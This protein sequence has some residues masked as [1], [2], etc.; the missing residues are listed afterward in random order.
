M[1]KSKMWKK[2]LVTLAL[3]LTSVLAIGCSSNVE[4]AAAVAEP[5][6]FPTRTVATEPLPGATIAEGSDS[7]Y[8]ANVGE[9]AASE[10]EDTVSA[11]A[12]GEIAAGE[13]SDSEAAG[14]IY[15]LEEE[16]LARDVYLTLQE[17]WGMNIL[18]NI[19]R[20]EE[21]H[22][23]AVKTLI[24]RYNLID[25]VAGNAIGEFTDRDL[26]SLYDELVEKGSQSLQAALEV[27]AA[28]EE[29][30]IIDLEQYMAQTDEQDIQRVYENLLQGSK[31]HL[32]SFVSVYE[33]N[34][35]TYQPQHLSQVEFDEIIDATMER[36]GMSS[37][38]N[39]PGGTG[40]GGSGRGGSGND[41]RDAGRTA[42]GRS[43]G[44][45]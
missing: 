13:L 41:S 38:R 5:I 19:A 35:G 21:T 31:N 30:D 6:E 34:A 1:I 26:Q 37:G 27:G 23:G 24:D 43:G 12:V 40:N 9:A 33:K 15:M 3:A 8:I 29:I 39:S 16:K 32:R 7:D 22:M 36:G 28:I 45:P 11:D 14:I 25:P 44:R 4:A 2:S 42:N 20:S 10:V 17:K 18:G